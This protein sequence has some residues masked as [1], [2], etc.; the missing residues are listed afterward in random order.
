MLQTGAWPRMRRTVSPPMALPFPLPRLPA[1]PEDPRHRGHTRLQDFSDTHACTHGPQPR[2]G[3]PGLPAP[4]HSPGLPVPLQDPSSRSAFLLAH[5]Q[6]CLTLCDPV[7]CSPPGSSHG[8]SRDAKGNHGIS[9]ARALQRAA[10]PPP[11]ALPDPGM[12]RLSLASPALASGSF[13]T[14]AWEAQ[15]FFALLLSH[16]CQYSRTPLIRT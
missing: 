13:A 16:K 11:G 9:Q 3:L 1:L 8:T 10:V 4:A 6:L 14:A 2:A 7:H 15:P 12:E 5:A